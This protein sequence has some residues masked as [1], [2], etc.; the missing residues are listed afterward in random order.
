VSIA[1]PLPTLFKMSDARR[2]T[3]IMSFM[4]AT[5]PYVTGILVL[6][7]SW[8]LRKHPTGNRLP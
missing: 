6:F 1:I 2:R 3:L 8:H 4:K 5:A 7:V